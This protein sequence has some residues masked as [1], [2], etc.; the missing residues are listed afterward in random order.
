MAGM[1]FMKRKTRCDFTAAS[2]FLNI[3]SSE[4][5]PAGITFFF[6]AKSG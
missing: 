5:P 2:I 6:G 3:S 4:A 1:P